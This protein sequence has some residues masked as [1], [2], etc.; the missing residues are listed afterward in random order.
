MFIHNYIYH[1]DSERGK[2]YISLETHKIYIRGVSC[3][4][5]YILIWLYECGEI[6]SIG[7]QQQQKTVCSILHST[8]WY[9]ILLFQAHLQFKLFF[10]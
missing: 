2:M 7:Q 5:L 10:A 9:Y 1:F 4:T 3:L 8:V 6:K